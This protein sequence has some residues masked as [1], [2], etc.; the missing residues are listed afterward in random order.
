MFGA[1][2]GVLRAVIG[3]LFHLHSGAGCTTHLIAIAGRISLTRAG[4]R[5]IVCTSRAISEAPIS[6]AGVSLVPDPP[7]PRPLMR[8][9]TSTSA[10]S[11]LL[12]LRPSKSRNKRRSVH[13]SPWRTRSRSAPRPLSRPRVWPSPQSLSVCVC[14]CALRPSL[15]PLPELS[16]HPSR[17]LLPR[18]CAPK[19]SFGSW[20]LL[21]LVLFA[22][23]VVSSPRL[24]H[25]VFPPCRRFHFL[26]AMV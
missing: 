17:R 22:R 13:S 8:R 11:T 20:L 14:A 6:I 4:R 26:V 3:S 25:S 1:A 7:P 2:L 5:R 15:S 18:Y 16:E 12:P 21:R 24:N 23:Y 10:L 19:C 9:L